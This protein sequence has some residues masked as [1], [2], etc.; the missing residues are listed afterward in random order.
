MHESGVKMITKEFAEAC[1]EIDEILRYLPL[2]YVSKI[3]FKLRDFFRKVAD[4]KYVSKIDPYKLL[5]EQELLP[6]TKTLITI[7]YR[8]YWCTESERAELDKVLAENE[9][10]YM[11][12]LEKN[13]EI[14]ANEE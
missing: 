2:E 3:P 8:N 10:K 13:I 5:D 4:K 7:L 9:R 1:S 6:K 14:P 11:L 12:E